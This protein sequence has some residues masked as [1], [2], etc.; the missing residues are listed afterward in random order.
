MISGQPRN[1][2][3]SALQKINLSKR[4]TSRRYPFFALVIF[5]ATSISRLFNTPCPI[6]IVQ[7]SIPCF[8]K[9]YWF[10]VF[11]CV[12]LFPN[13]RMHGCVCSLRAGR[14]KSVM[15]LL[16]FNFKTRC[17]LLRVWSCMLNRMHRCS[18]GERY[19]I[20]LEQRSVLVLLLCHNKNA[21][22][23]W[24]FSLSKV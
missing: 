15:I 6:E 20:T 3:S 11:L 21:S 13:V 23:H 19:I 12:R 5:F 8:V 10:Y 9:F 2:I 14:L 24:S 18:C 22:L 16:Y 17:R 1:L 7:E 4:K